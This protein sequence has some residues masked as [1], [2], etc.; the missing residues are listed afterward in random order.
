[1]TSRAMRDSDLRIDRSARTLREL[2]L[3]KLRDAILDFRFKPGERL[4]ER[5]LCELF[6]VS[7]TVVREVLRHLEAEGLVETLPQQGP[8]VVKPDIAQAA[9]IYDIR[10][11]LE[12]DAA[13][14]A[15]HSATAADV[16]RLRAA[17]GVIQVAFAADSSRDVLK[18]T[19]DFYE[20][21]FTLARKPVAWSMVQA[22]NARISHLRRLTIATPERR[23]R[24][25][26]EMRRI[27]DAIAARD[28]EEAAHA[29][30]DHVQIVAALAAA[31]LSKNEFK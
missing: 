16:E 3:E 13:R 31:A 4:V 30:F 17:N 12:A 1:M 25:D 14:G 18:A 21:L 29:S 11:L 22:L 15:A 2:T 7:R 20:F 6:G 8:A 9:E 10:A 27:I 28:A 23:S 26:A 5:N 24:A 19:T